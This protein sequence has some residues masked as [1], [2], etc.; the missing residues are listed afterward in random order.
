MLDPWEP[1][2]RQRFA[3]LLTR[4]AHE[5]EKSLEPPPRERHG[6]WHGGPG[7]R[8]EAAMTDASTDA[9]KGDGG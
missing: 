9:S 3:E 6:R 4:F 2:D 5:F 1:G 8:P 7:A